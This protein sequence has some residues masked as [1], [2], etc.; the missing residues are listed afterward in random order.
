MLYAGGKKITLC[1]TKKIN[2]LTLVLSE[3]KILNETKNHNPPPFELNSRSLGHELGKDQE[4]F[5]NTGVSQP[6]EKEA[7]DNTV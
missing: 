3:E 7:T 1:A 4:V 6:V 5:E 2:I